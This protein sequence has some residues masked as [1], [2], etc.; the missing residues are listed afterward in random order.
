M[1]GGLS[2]AYAVG[3]VLVVAATVA[4][5]AVGGT[6]APPTWPQLFVGLDGRAPGLAPGLVRPIV[7]ASARAATTIPTARQCAARWNQYA[8]ATTKH[9]L[10]S[11][12]ARSADITEMTTGAQVIGTS[13]H[14]VFSQ[15]A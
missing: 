5:L 3:A 1:K 14:Y 2:F 8:P 6:A 10:A 15:C 13:K 7:P 4:A 12:G 11:H 9:W